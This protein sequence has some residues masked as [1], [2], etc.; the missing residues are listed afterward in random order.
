VRQWKNVDD[1]I[2]WISVPEANR[3][4][5]KDRNF[6]LSPRNCR[7]LDRYQRFG[8]WIQTN[9]EVW[10]SHLG[11]YEGRISFTDGRHRFAWFRDHGLETLPVTTARGD[12]AA[13]RRAVGLSRTTSSAKL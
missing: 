10:M 4:W 7:S 3:L 13:L 8:E 6:Y 9:T 5:R 2:V 1:V 11:L 12:G